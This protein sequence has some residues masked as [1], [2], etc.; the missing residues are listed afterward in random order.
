MTAA[1]DRAAR[2]RRRRQVERIVDKVCHRFD[3]SERYA[4]QVTPE[5]RAQSI[6]MLMEDPALISQWDE[7]ARNL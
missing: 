6:K 7:Y 5:L 4:G 1:E 2:R 3:K